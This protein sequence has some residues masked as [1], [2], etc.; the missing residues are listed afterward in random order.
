MHILVLHQTVGLLDDWFDGA[1][2][3]L[4]F[5]YVWLVIVPLKHLVSEQASCLKGHYSSTG[6]S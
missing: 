3:F 4:I 6:P 1:L 2:A 5:Y